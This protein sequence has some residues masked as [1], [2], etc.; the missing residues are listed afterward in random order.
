MFSPL[1][2]VIIV[3]LS[4]LEHLTNRFLYLLCAYLTR[5]LQHCNRIRAIVKT[6]VNKTMN[7]QVPH[8][9][10]ISLK[11]EPLAASQTYVCCLIFGIFV[12]R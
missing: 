12:W 3:M 6:R 7:S 11:A 8:G 1:I 9:P 10:E 4:L 2:R 5:F